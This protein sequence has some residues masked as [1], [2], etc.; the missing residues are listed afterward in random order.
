MA[1]IGYVR[2]STKEQNTDRQLD[3][4]QL[5]KIFKEKASGK[6][7]KDRPALK[8]CLNYLREGDTL[9]VH[10][11]DRLARSLAHLNEVVQSL[12]EQ[13]VRVEFVS[14]RL[15]FAKDSQDLAAELMLNM[16]G[17]IAQFE[18]RLMKR[19]QKEG[20]AKA[21]ERGVYKGR[22]PSLTK[23]EKIEIYN[24]RIKEEISVKKL[25]KDYGVSRTT[26]FRVVKEIKS[27]YEKDSDSI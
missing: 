9:Y 27:L 12:T 11:I 6:N 5:D 20:I 10:D 13:G 24:K 18:H 26:I 17:A 19:R 23:D 14:E 16:L 15:S 22:K 8:E 21:K 25:V 4:I 3:G 2:V 1:K 7:I